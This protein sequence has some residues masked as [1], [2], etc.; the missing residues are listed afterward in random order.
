MVI[1]IV[2]YPRLCMKREKNERLCRF[3]YCL[4]YFFMYK[5]LP[6][7]LKSNLLLGLYK[8]LK[9]TNSS[10]SEFRIGPLIAVQLPSNQSDCVLILNPKVK[11]IIQHIWVLCTAPYQR[12][13][14]M[15]TRDKFRNAHF[16]NI[17]CGDRKLS[18]Q[19]LFGN[20]FFKF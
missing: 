3:C 17:R 12:L 4:K 20:F 6:L 5:R 15:D 2:T 14:S 7:F 9:H 11:P 13:I 10:K 8:S 19:Q 16:R 1:C 18:R